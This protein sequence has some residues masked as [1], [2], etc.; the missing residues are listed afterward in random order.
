MPESRTR[1]ILKPGLKIF[2]L[3][4]FVLAMANAL[5]AY[6][7]SSFLKDIIGQSYVGLFFAVTHFL[8]LIAVSN[9]AGYINK[10]KIFKA[11]FSILLLEILSL[12][13]ISFLPI[14]LATV[15]FLTFYLTSAFLLWIILDIYIEYFSR[16]AVTGRIRG[17]YMTLINTAWVISPITTGFILKFFGYQQLYAVSNVL[18]FLVLLFFFI[19]FRQLR[20]DHFPKPYFFRAIRRIYKNKSLNKIFGIAFILHSFYA[21]MVIYAPIYLHEHIGLTWQELGI[22]FTIMLLP[23]TLIQ[24]PAGYI[25]DKYLGE[26][27][28]L[29]VGLSIIGISLFIFTFTRSTNFLVWAAILFC[30]RVGASLVEIMRDTYFFKQVN[31]KDVHIINLFRNTSNLA[32]IIMPLVATLTLKFFGFRYLFGT[33]ALFG[34]SGLVFSLRLKD[35]R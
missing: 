30:T 11:G 5:V 27:E 34:L 26:K 3:F 19:K 7:Q 29:S 28:I 16:D 14:S 17:I 31:V 23:F 9:L 10:V 35:T 2:I 4:G 24:Y 33:M 6:I 32:Y 13:F 21:V 1:P 25:A 15:I 22:V 8:V 12:S 20:V 18:V